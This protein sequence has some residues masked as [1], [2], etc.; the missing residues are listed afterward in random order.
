MSLLKKWT[1]AHSQLREIMLDL[2]DDKILVKKVAKDTGLDW[3]SIDTDGPIRSVWHAVIDE[4]R[5]QDALAKMVDIVAEQY[6]KHA[7]ALKQALTGDHPIVES[8][9]NIREDVKW[10]S[11]APEG[12]LEQLMGK[13]STLLP[14][15]FLELGLQRSRSVAR[16]VTAGGESGTGFL[17]GKNLL[18]TNN[19]VLPDKETAAGA[20]VEFN[21]EQSTTGLDKPIDR[22]KFRPDQGFLT[23]PVKVHDWTIVRVDGDP[24]AKWGSIPLATAKV[25]KEQRVVIIQHPGGGQKQIALTHNIVTFVDDNLVQYLTDTMPG[26]SGS[27]VFNESWEL[28][29]LHHSGGWLREPGSKESLFRNEGIAIERV[30]SGG[31][32]LLGA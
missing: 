29:A 15:G 18:I 12:Q 25:A 28:V 8:P 6:P 32:E 5:K 11:D 9:V 10:K 13:Q 27:P 2:Y 19:H 31:K 16:V 3:G 14:V 23:S 26:S 21:Y 1:A 30:L 7:A 20:T 17:V 22:Y 24:N 4:G